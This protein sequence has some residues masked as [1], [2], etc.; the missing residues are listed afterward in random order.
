MERLQAMDAEPIA[1][2]PDVGIGPE[3][4]R[5]DGVGRGP[6]SIAARLQP[7]RLHHGR[8]AR[9]Y[10]GLLHLQMLSR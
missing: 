3:L 7:A 10:Q 4:E 2:R 8:A 5:R 9:R 1:A 6:V